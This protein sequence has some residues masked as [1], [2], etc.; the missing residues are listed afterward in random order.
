MKQRNMMPRVFTTAI[1]LAFALAAHAQI[2]G[3]I[4]AKDISRAKELVSRMT[5][6]EKL[7]LISG[8]DDG[9][10]LRP[11]ERLGIPALQMHDGPQGIGQGIKGMFF[12]CGM[13]TAATWDRNMA[14]LVGESLAT[15]FKDHNTD[16]ILGP[17]VNIY[18]ATLCG[19]NFEYF[20]EDPYLASETAKHYILGVQSKGVIATIK[21]FAANNMEWGR[22]DVNSNVDLRT[23][24]EIYLATFRKAVKEAKVGAVMDSYNLLYGLHTTESRYLNIDLLR[25]KWGFK[26]IVMSDWGAVHSTVATANGGLDLEMPSSQY[27]KP[28]LVKEALAKGLVSEET[29]NE[30]VQHILQTMSAFG[31]L[32]KSVG[33]KNEPNEKPELKAAAL[34]IAESGITLLKNEDDV[35]P[36]GKQRF[37]VIGPNADKIARGGGSGQVNF[38]SAVTPWAGIKKAFGKQAAFISDEKYKTLINGAFFTDASLSRPGLKAEYFN[39]KNLEGTPS[40]TRTEETP[41]VSNDTKMPSGLSNANFS[42]RWSGVFKAANTGTVIFQFTGDDGYRMTV[43]G[44]TLCNEWRDQA[45]KKASCKLNTEAGKTYS[46]TIEY[47]QGGG[48]QK[49]GLAMFEY[50][51]GKLDTQLK[52]FNTAVVVAGYDTDTEGEGFDRTFNL[53]DPQ[54]ELISHIASKVGNVIVVANSGGGFN[55]MPWIYNVKGVIMAWYPGQEG[56]TAIANILKGTVNPSGKLPMSIEKQWEDNPVHDNF[57]A[58]DGV[59]EI[60]YKEGLFYGYRGYDAQG[61]RPLF[62]FGFGLSYTTFSYSCIK[63]QPLGKHRLRVTFN[64]TNTGSRAGAE[65]AQLYVCPLNSKVVRPVKELK[66]YEKVFLKKG[67]TK[68]V[69]IDLDEDAFSY[70]DIT[71]EDF[72][73]DNGSFRIMAGPSSDDLPLQTDVIF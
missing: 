48:D 6:D 33:K 29:I 30:K 7:S 61:K 55:F 24:N 60:T 14:K 54:N 38:H 21:H 13:L 44:K 53:P 52:N 65:V 11:I 46:I 9:M 71:A 3:D 10:S 16:V 18:R 1:A 12:P 22:M 58:P 59:K 27:W 41:M 26:G 56:G 20:G 73:P 34:K 45:A 69:T 2:P 31:V 5:L 39:N 57:F 32:D 4:T 68:S 19:R 66:G 49:F 40:A 25:K 8:N 36:I 15:D 62:P 23:L 51:F 64:I 43:D 50:D 35:L 37:A 47:Y 63:A 17:G 42:I 67:E 70:Y 28:E 72:V